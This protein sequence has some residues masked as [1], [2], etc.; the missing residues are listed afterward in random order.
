MESW[1]G[2]FPH[3]RVLRGGGAETAA[4]NA[5][6]IHRARRNRRCQRMRDDKPTM[7]HDPSNG[8]PTWTTGHQKSKEHRHGP[9]RGPHLDRETGDDTAGTT[10]GGPSRKDD[11]APRLH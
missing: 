11:L 7:A 6:T 4:G 5:L 2:S 3:A 1:T 10:D 8:A 9:A